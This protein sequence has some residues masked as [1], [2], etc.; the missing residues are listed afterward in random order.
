MA[1]AL[2]VKTTAS[3]AARVAP[4]V[5]LAMACPRV[6][7]VP[8]VPHVPSAASLLV[9]FPCVLFALFA[10]FI[11]LVRRLGP[12]LRA[13]LRKSGLAT[14]TPHGHLRSGAVAWRSP[15]HTYSPSIAVDHALELPLSPAVALAY[16]AANSVVV[17]LPT[18]EGLGA[19]RRTDLR[20]GP[21][22]GTEGTAVAVVLGY[23][24][25]TGWLPL[26][27][28]LLVLAVRARRKML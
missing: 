18:P 27:P 28:E 12:L 3:A 17:L 9:L 15:R 4:V 13:L 11:R 20:S 19:G 21:R 22:R 7:R 14:P 10:P 25:L 6:L 1:I 24:L 26:V 16:L 5:R 2:T 23:R 8:H